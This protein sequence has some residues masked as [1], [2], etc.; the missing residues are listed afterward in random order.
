MNLI[1]RIEQDEDTSAEDIRRMFGLLI[2]HILAIHWAFE[3]PAFVIRVEMPLRLGSRG[4]NDPALDLI[5]STMT[6]PA[7]YVPWPSEP[8][9]AQWFYAVTYWCRWKRQVRSGFS[10]GISAS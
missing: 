3:A 2:N 6:R 9:S 4:F 8:L 1:D 5:A 10:T 7:V